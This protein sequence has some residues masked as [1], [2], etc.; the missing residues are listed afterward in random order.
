MVDPGHFDITEYHAAIRG[1]IGQLTSPGVC[2][3]CVLIAC[4]LGVPHGG[5]AVLSPRGEGTS[6]MR[7]ALRANRHLRAAALLSR[8]GIR[9]CERDVDTPRGRLQLTATGGDYHVL[10]AID[11]VY[12]RCGI[13]GVRKLRLP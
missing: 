1:I 12:A 5:D 8:L 7:A 9:K 3:I 6:T 13:A 10:L 2:C 11:P 4:R